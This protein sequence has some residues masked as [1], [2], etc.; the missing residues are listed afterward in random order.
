MKKIKYLSEKIN[1]LLPVANCVTN[2]NNI[3]QVTNGNIVANGRIHKYWRKQKIDIFK[4]TNNL[5][6]FSDEWIDTT[7]YLQFFNLK[8]VEFGNWTNQ[9]DR[10]AMMY[11]GADSLY[12]LSLLINVEPIKM[13]L[14]Q[15]LSTAYGARGFGK[16]YATYENYFLAIIN[17][18]KTHAAKG[19]FAHEYAHAL[20]NLLGIE[21]NY[22]NYVSKGNNTSFEIDTERLNS[23]NKFVSLAENIIKILYYDNS[24]NFT[25]F[26]NTLKKED[27][28]YWSRSKEVFARA[29]EKWV[30]YRIGK[31]SNTMFIKN[32]EE[33]KHLFYPDIK[34][35]KKI[36]NLMYEFFKEGIEFLNKDL[37]ETKEIKENT[38]VNQV[39]V[40]PN[41]TI[42]ENNNKVNNEKKEN[43]KISYGNETTIVTP[44]ENLKAKYAIIEL[45]RLITSNDPFT[46]SLNPNYPKDCQT[47]SYKEDEAEQVKVESYTKNFDFRHLINTSPDATTG[48]PIINENDIVLG[49]N[50]RTMILYR[51]NKYFPDKFKEYISELKKVSKLLFGID[52]NIIDN[53]SNPVLVRVI[54]GKIDNCSKISNILNKSNAN[55]YDEIREGIAYAKQLELD[56]NA[57]DIIGDIFSNSEA[58]TFSQLLQDKNATYSI[59]KLL[60]DKKIINT[61]NLQSL[62]VSNTEFTKKG[63]NFLEILLLASLLPDKKLINSAKNYTLKILKALPSLIRIKNLPPDYSIINEIQD[64]IRLESKRRATNLKFIDFIAQTNAF[65]K[66]IEPITLIVYKILDRTGI[67]KFKDFANYFADRAQEA[68]FGENMFGEKQTK[69]DILNNYLVGNNLKDNLRINNLKD[70]EYLINEFANL[71]FEIPIR[72]AI[73]DEYINIYYLDNLIARI[74]LKHYTVDYYEQTVLFGKSKYHKHFNLLATL[75]IKYIKKLKYIIKNRININNN[76]VREKLLNSN[77]K[78]LSVKQNENLNIVDINGIMKIAKEVSEKFS[79]TDFIA[80]F[81]NELRKRNFDNVSVGIISLILRD[82]DKVIN[83]WDIIPKEY[84]ETKNTKELSVKQNE[85]LN[86]VDINGIMKIAKEVSE[87]FNGKYFIIEFRKELKKRKFDN[88]NVTNNFDIE[89]YHNGKYINVWRLIPPVYYSD[90]IHNYSLFDNTKNRI[91]VN[92]IKTENLLSSKSNQL[93]IEQYENLFSSGNIIDIYGILEIAKEVSQKYSGS[94]FLR[95]FK[96]EIAN[97]NFDNVF[98][99]SNIFALRHKGQNINILDIIPKVYY[100]NKIENYT[101]FDNAEKEINIELEP[102]EHIEID[103]ED[104]KVNKVTNLSNIINIKTIPLKLKG[105]AKLLLQNLNKPFRML[106]WG[107]QGSG[108]STFMLQLVNDISENGKILLHINEEKI[109]SGRITER[110][111]KAGVKNL[112]N[113]DIDDSGDY[114]KLLELINSN[115]YFCVVIDSKDNFDFDEELLLDI[116]YNYPKISFILISHSQKTGNNYTGNRKFAHLA[117]TEI[118][119]SKGIAKTVKHR[120]CV[121]ERSVQVFNNNNNIIPIRNIFQIN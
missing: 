104:N 111:K 2:T 75:L 45:N 28:E 51:V 71:I 94:D 20:D 22:S 84:Y 13:G 49:G 103:T 90:E 12:Q 89:L 16:G 105:K 73:E 17:I 101:L 14:S 8:S 61:T 15:K 29:F 3:L 70:Y 39:V 121:A 114:N 42:N 21:T 86:I 76:N 56:N 34:L 116:W 44:S 79:A 74:N 32:N 4:Y 58:E 72:V 62:L 68:L 100:S 26:A 50:A 108:K 43:L 35:I 6:N 47:R 55:E 118:Q 87:K 83:V 85:N 25:D 59:I 119:V 31:T 19:T 110:I 9:E 109:N 11:A 66:E 80:E 92:N 60:Q 7:K 67:N 1:N 81:K 88:L 23:K 117:D 91:N 27:K 64:S 82:N 36:D 24:N 52:E 113:I 48:S 30:F 78:E 96:K 33:Y 99:S 69:F 102:N 97:R 37:N 57:L 115:K 112:D 98:V 5:Y 106:I 41:S 63:E 120:D 93:F 65:D 54:A 46:F 53:Y 107:K 77:S 40:K 10:I 95:E 38:E 18:T